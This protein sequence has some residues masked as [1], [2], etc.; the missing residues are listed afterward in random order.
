MRSTHCTA[1]LNAA[2]PRNSRICTAPAPATAT[3]QADPHA[4][5]HPRARAHKRGKGAH[6]KLLRRKRDRSVRLG[7]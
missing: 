3:A 5:T 1:L 4:V 7:R 2:A 6:Q